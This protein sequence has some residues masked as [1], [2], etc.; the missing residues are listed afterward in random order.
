MCSGLNG[1]HVWTPLIYAVIRKAV[2]E[3]HFMWT[4][5][6]LV[7]L[8]SHIHTWSIKHESYAMY[9]VSLTPYMAGTHQIGKDWTALSNFYRATHTTRVSASLFDVIRPSYTSNV[10]TSLNYLFSQFEGVTCFFWHDSQQ[11]D[12]IRLRFYCEQFLKYSVQ[13]SSR[14]INT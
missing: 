13:H 9:I 11:M 14:P 6:G 2:Q 5:Y 4:L 1:E 12:W 10:Q 3:Q 7:G 8:R